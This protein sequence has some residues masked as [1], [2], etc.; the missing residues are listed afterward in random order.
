MG[1]G[2][3][4][5]EISIFTSNTPTFLTTEQSLL[6]TFTIQLET[7]AFFAFTALKLG[8][9]KVPGASVLVITVNA[10]TVLSAFPILGVAKTVSG[11]ALGLGTVTLD[12][13]ARSLFEVGL[14]Q[15]IVDHPVT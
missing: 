5:F 10:P 6:A 7:A 2:P 15:Q 9:P 13:F 8:L 3:F 14:L 12:I 11:L 4:L 1:L